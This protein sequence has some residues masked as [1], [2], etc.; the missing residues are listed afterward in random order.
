MRR[1]CTVMSKSLAAGWSQGMRLDNRS[2]CVRVRFCMKSDQYRCCM[3]VPHTLARYRN[4]SSGLQADKA[5]SSRVLSTGAATLTDMVKIVSV[6][7]EACVLYIGG[8]YVTV[9]RASST[10]IRDRD[11][12]TR[13]SYIHLRCSDVIP[14]GVKKRR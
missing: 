11:V 10:L 12:N 8:R 9:A 3:A 2:I 6:R 4:R 7:M 1:L 13:T 14:L 5:E